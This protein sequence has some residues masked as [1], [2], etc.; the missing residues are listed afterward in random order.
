ME[1]WKISQLEQLSSTN[2]LETAYR[3]SVNFAKNMGFR[4]FGFSTSYTS[5]TERLSA[6]RL[7]NY[8][9]DWNAD[10]EKRKLARIDPVVA[11]CFQ[12]AIPVLWTEELFDSTQ[13]LWNEL[14]Q[15]GLQHG[16]S[17][18]VHDEN[19]GLC[20]ILSLARSH[21]PISAWELYE[22]QG[23]S[24]FIGHHLHKLVARALPKGLHTVH[25]AI[26]S[27]GN[28]RVETGRGWQNGLRKRQDSQSQ[29]ANDQFPCS[30]NHPQIRSKQ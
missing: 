7:N 28:R 11:H 2:D 8:P 14:E 22:N 20:S 24:V 13:C 26:V 9:S 6:L 30:G 23:Y 27:S 10:Y 3:I 5:N 4:F 19:S 16:W 17:Q 1:K 25:P 18:A 29:P 12:S 15:Q 21:C